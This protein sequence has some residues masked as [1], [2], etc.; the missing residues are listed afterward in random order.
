MTSLSYD[1]VFDDFLG[2]VADY[3]F[4]I[5]DESTANYLMSEYL[6]KVLA[7]PYI[8]RLFSSVSADKEIHLIQFEVA[9]KVDDDADLEFVK[10][11]LSKGMVVEW[12]E[13]QV[14]NKVNISQFFGGKEQK[15]YSQSNHIAELRGL[16]EDT[17]RELRGEIRDRGY[18]YN[19]YLENTK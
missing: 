17:E 3:D 1:E 8:R 6:Q 18:I 15:F 16:L 11:I 4:S 9:E 5:M 12:L 7:R 13:P 14:K 19:P 10:T 2:R